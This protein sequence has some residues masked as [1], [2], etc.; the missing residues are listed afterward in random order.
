MKPPDER[1]IIHSTKD[2]IFVIASL[3]FHGKQCL[4]L[5]GLAIMVTL[6]PGIPNS[7]VRMGT[8]MGPRK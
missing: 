3:R 7:I 2:G 4:R 5:V 1:D 8:G 6:I